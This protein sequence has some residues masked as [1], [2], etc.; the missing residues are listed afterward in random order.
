[1]ITN[2]IKF[3]YVMIQKI[4]SLGNITSKS[5]KFLYLKVLFSKLLLEHLMREVMSIEFL[6]VKITIKN[7][8]GQ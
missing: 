3:G 6:L 8:I 2:F 4:I 1:M 7:M 5:N